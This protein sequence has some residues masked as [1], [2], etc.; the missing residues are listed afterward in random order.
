VEASKVR[1]NPT[2]NS[3]VYFTLRNPITCGSPARSDFYQSQV[4]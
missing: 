4:A 3:P 1:L 2:Y